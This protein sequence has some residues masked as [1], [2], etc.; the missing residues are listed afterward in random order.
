MGLISRVSSRT[1]RHDNSLML[2]LVG[3]SDNETKTLKKSPK[4]ILKCSF[5]PNKPKNKISIKI[6]EK[7]K[8]K[9]EKLLHQLK[10]RKS[11]TAIPSC[12]RKLKRSISEP[13]KSKNKCSFQI[14]KVGC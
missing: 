13:C 6:S 8:E 1:Y 2:Q 12:S 4:L 7:L 10:K 3:E 14:K 5:Y 9:N 11:S